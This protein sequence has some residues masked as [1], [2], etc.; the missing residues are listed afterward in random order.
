MSGNRRSTWLLAAAALLS[1]GLLLAPV[2]VAAPVADPV[3]GLPFA[4]GQ[5][6]Y[7]AGVHSD[8]GQ[9]GVKNAIDFSPS[10]GIARSAAAGTVRM[11]SCSGGD[12]VT[13]DHSDG[14]RTGYYHLEDIQVQ[15]GQEVAAGTP[16]GRTGNALPCGGSSSGAHVHFTLWQLNAAPSTAADW[17]G[18]SYEEVST[19]VAA[20]VGVPVDGKVFGAWRIRAGAQQYSGRAE[21]VSDGF[22]VT[23]PGRFRV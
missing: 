7:S 6:T 12:W 9:S 1:G 19:R 15:D 18:L 8:N 16:L 22:S 17:S 4:T 3:L 2:A 14:W 5:Q 11:Q 10:D 23:L 13:V 21:R 20:E